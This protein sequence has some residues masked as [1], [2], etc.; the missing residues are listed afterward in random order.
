MVKFL[1][2]TL[3]GIVLYLVLTRAKRPPPERR[4][5][6]RPSDEAMVRC[7]Y[8]GIHVPM[9]ESL[10]GG[11]RRYCSEEHRRLGQ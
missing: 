6:E 5:P 4:E 9:G 7:A 3:I 11:D 8:C 10:P 2:L 1:F